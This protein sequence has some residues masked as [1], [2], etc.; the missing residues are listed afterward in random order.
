MPTDLGFNHWLIGIGLSA[1]SVQN[2]LSRL[3]KMRVQDALTEDGFYQFLSEHRKSYSEASVNKHI[4]TI[5]KYL[6]YNKITWNNPPHRIKEHNRS[7]E[8]ISDDEINTIITHLQ[9]KYR[10]FFALLAHTGLRPSEAF[11]L[12]HTCFDLARNVICIRDTKTFKDRVIPIHEA[13]TPFIKTVITGK[14]F[15]FSDTAA[16][17][18][19]NKVCDELQITRKKIYAFRHSFVTRLLDSDVDLFSVKLLAGHSDTRSTERYYHSSLKRLK[20]AIQKDA[21]GF[22]SMPWTKKLQIIAIRLKE[23][24]EAIKNDPDIDYSVTETNEEIIIRVKKK[25][26]KK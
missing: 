8:T 10:F 7:P 26:T 3:E 12:D 18:E 14:Q 11:K 25:D 15:N 9:P 22:V 5:R 24:L 17:T 6:Q 16:R 23:A 13:L 20:V 19:L 1:K 4:D 21:L 2:T